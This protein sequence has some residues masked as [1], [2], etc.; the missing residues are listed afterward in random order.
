[1]IP[2]QNLKSVPL[3]ATLPDAQ[4]SAL[5]AF[6]T[7]KRYP[8][9]TIVLRI[10]AKASGLY[11][12]LSGRAKVLIP[13]DTGREV[14]LSH[15][16]APDF[17]GEMGLFDDRRCLASVK[18]LEPSEVL[19]ISRADFM[20]CLSENV[21]LGMRLTRAVVKR[22]READ[23]Q[24]ESLALMD[25][26][27]RVARVLM[28]LAEQVDGKTVIVKPPPKQE[29]ASMIGATREMVYRVMKGLQASGHILIE[30]RRIVL[31]DKL[32]TRR[33]PVVG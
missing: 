22:L 6:A 5:T 19:H 18:T 26:Y 1:M 21:E 12:I 23:R 16:N 14:I 17:F 33:P 13:D 24:I 7:V 28:D 10:G 30:K 27:G 8:R 15:L 11:V 29:I 31:L 20:R 2:T 4:L 25:V 32:G 3:F 9:N